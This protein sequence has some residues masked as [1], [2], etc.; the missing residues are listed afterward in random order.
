MLQRSRPP[1]HSL[2]IYEVAIIESQLIEFLSW[3]PTLKLLDLRPPDPR[4]PDGSQNITAKFWGALTGIHPSQLDSTLQVDDGEPYLP[5]SGGRIC[6]R[7]EKLRFYF[8]GKVKLTEVA[9][10]IMCRFPSCDHASFQSRKVEPEAEGKTLG[11]LILEECD[12][13]EEDFLAYP[14]M[15]KYAE[16]GLIVSISDHEIDIRLPNEQDW[17]W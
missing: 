13:S 11:H 5:P 10:V 14:G 16:A 12:F 4:L 17:V 3:T 2:H 1:L 8:F 7:L 15:G 9:A 6:P